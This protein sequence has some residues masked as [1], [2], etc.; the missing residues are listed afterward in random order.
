MPCRSD[1]L[2]RRSFADDAARRCDAVA[3][4]G[5][6]AGAGQSGR[7]AGRRCLAGP[8]RGC[9]GRADRRRPAARLQ[10]GLAAR[11]TARGGAGAGECRRAV[12][13]RGAGDQ[14]ACHHGRR[15]EARHHGGIGRGQVGAGRYHRG[16]CGGG[17]HRGRAD[18]R[19]RARGFGFRVPPHGRAPAGRHRGGRRPRRSRPQPA[20]AR[21]AI[22]QRDC[23][24]LP[25]AGQARA[26]DPRQ[27][28]P[29]RP[30]RARTGAGAGRAG[31]GTGLS[32]IR[33]GRRHAAG[34]A[35]GQFGPDGRGGNGDLHRAGRWR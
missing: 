23:R 13:L 8:C 2:S 30:R 9:A 4:A 3:S 32:A 6:G 10:T 15:P 29:R 18:R 14:C 19:T 24:I 33:S 28:H 34:G 11:R 27:S 12:R 35:G 7:G 16:P 21:R 5:A 26:A 22:C 20:A 17:C 25:R 31:R 1:R